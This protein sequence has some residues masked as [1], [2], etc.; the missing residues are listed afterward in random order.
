LFGIVFLYCQKSKIVYIHPFYSLWDVRVIIFGLVIMLHSYLLSVSVLGFVDDKT[1]MVCCIQVLDSVCVS[2]YCQWSISFILTCSFLAVVVWVVL[3]YSTI[4]RKPVG[5]YCSISSRL[6]S[7]LVTLCN[8]F[9][10]SKQRLFSPS[11]L[12]MSLLHTLLC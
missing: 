7:L 8:F 6:L 12:S 5:K 4:A 9:G 1:I 11:I 10:I 3:Q 2:F